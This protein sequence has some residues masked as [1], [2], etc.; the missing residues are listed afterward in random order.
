M[1]WEVNRMRKDLIVAVLLTFCLTATLL[2]VATSRSQEYDPWADLNGDGKIDIL[3]VVGTTGKY[4][5]TGDPTK[6]VWVTNWP[7]S[8]NHMV[9]W[10]TPTGDAPL[11][12]A[13]SEQFDAQGFTYM[14]V[15][16]STGLDLNGSPDTVTIEI[17]GMLW[18]QSTPGYKP[19][20]LQTVGLSSGFRDYG[21]TIPVPSQ[22][23]YF[24]GRSSG[25]SHTV[26]ASFYLTWG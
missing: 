5:T 16:L 8:G 4:A 26:F 12:R 23:F 14:H 6:N 17:Y 15:L 20:L 22:Q 13:Y 11:G 1:R 24:V 18:D 10:E 19:V 21:F 7:S 3:D 2:M 9:W 25:V